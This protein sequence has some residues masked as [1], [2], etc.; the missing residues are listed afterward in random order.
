MRPLLPAIALLAL[1]ACSSPTKQGIAVGEP[2]PSA[3]DNG[4]IVM[5]QTNLQWKFDSVGTED[6]PRTKISLVIAGSGAS[7]TIELGTYAGAANDTT[8]TQTEALLSASVWWAGGG[9]DVRVLAGKNGSLV[10]QH[11]VTD[12]ESGFGDWQTLQTIKE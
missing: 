10:I 12:E 6:E 5:E 2:N 11:R 7:K 1:A 4:G 8:D 3:P 9:D